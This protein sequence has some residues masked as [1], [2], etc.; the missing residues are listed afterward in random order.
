MFKLRPVFEKDKNW[1]FALRNDKSAYKYFLNPKSVSLKEHSIWF[2]NVL[3]QKSEFVYIVLNM[4]NKK[5][6]MVKFSIKGTIAKIGINIEKN[7]RAK[8]LGTKI[9]KR[10][11]QLFFKK[12]KK[13]KK[14]IALIKNDNFPSVIAFSRAGYKISGIKGKII[15]LELLRHE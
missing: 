9:I 7:S 8:H 13:I 10:T 4:N 5:I 12:Y 15:T 11:S 2:S 3:F 14:I 6:A 1:L